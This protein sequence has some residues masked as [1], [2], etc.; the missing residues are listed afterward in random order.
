[1]DTCT[2]NGAALFGG[3]RDTMIKT[4]VVTMGVP[5]SGKT[6]Y[7]TAWVDQLVDNGLNPPVVCSDDIRAEISDAAD[8]TRND[9]V[10]DIARRRLSSALR[11]EQPVVFF[12]ATNIK[13]FAREDVLTLAE[14]NNAYTILAVLSCNIDDAKRRNAERE[15]VVPDHAMDRMH[16]EF[17]DQV[18]KL[19]DEGWDRIIYL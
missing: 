5:A 14:Q 16:G 7:V 10:F 12:D 3:V 1:M 9:V 6:T 8:Q 13:D 11:G 17:L 15:R 2:L 4:L 19:Q 18:G